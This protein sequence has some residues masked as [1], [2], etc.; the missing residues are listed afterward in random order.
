MSRPKIR[1]G[2]NKKKAE[3]NLFEIFEILNKASCQLPG[4]VV[5]E[6]NNILCIKAAH[7]DLCVMIVKVEKLQE[8]IE[9]MRSQISVISTEK[10][11]MKSDMRK[12]RPDNV[13]V[14]CPIMTQSCTLLKKVGTR[15]LCQRIGGKMTRYLEKKEANC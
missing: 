5:T 14:N 4:I 11:R 1:K 8:M 9:E 13:D 7:A 2:D 15:Q 6:L 3:G 10:Q 12:S